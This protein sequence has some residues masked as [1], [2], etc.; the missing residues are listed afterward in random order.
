METTPAPAPETYWWRTRRPLPSLVFLIPLL[1]VYEVGVFWIG[2]H[3]PEA[4]GNGADSW[5]RW[6]LEQ[7]GLSPF[8]VLPVAILLIFTAW[9]CWTREPW[10]L[11]GDVLLGMLTESLALAVALMVIGR[12][13][14]LAF[15]KLESSAI[16]ASLGPPP[17][18]VEKL[19]CYVGAG[20]YEETLFRLLLLPAVYYGLTSIG[21]PSVVAMTAAVTASALAFSGAHFVGPMAE[22]FVWFSFIFRWLAGL[23]F[24]GIFVL[25]GFGI[26]VGAHAAYDILVGVLHFQL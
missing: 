23:F 14:D 25:R 19:V 16:V 4:L 3:N 24:A 13:Q 22:P 18:E 10:Q 11:S 20:I 9:Q 12:M 26:A 17:A 5:M 1:T 2:G 7:A 6:A 15:Q 8:Y 21:F